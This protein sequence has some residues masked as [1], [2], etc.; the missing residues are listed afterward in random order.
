MT[1]TAKTGTKKPARK[2]ARAKPKPAG[3]REQ[4][5]LVVSVFGA[6]GSRVLVE[7]PTSLAEELFGEAPLGECAPH[8]VVDAIARDL[9]PMPDNLSS[10]SIAAVALALGRELEHPHNSATSKSMCA[11]RIT[12]IMGELRGLCPPE[13][14]ADSIDDLAAAREAR[15]AAVAAGRAASADLPR[16]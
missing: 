16:S 15:R 12:E 1:A 10:S 6:F 8:N 13:R 9:E 2:R 5:A 14:K 3:L 7:M 11:A 4:G